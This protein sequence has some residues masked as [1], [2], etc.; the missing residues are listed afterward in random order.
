MKSIFLIVFIYLTSPCL[1]QTSNDTIKVIARQIDN[2][3][4][5]NKQ[6][7]KYEVLKVL[8]GTLTN[9]TIN[10]HFQQSIE[11][12]SLSQTVLLALSIR[13]LLVDNHDKNLF[14]IYTAEA[15]ESVKIVLFEFVDWTYCESENASSKSTIINRDKVDDKLFLIAPCTKTGSMISLIAR[16]MD[17]AIQEISVRGLECPPAIELTNLSDGRYTVYLSSCDFCIYKDFNLSSKP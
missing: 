15:I 13:P 6:L 17:Q 11:D 16:G 1:G 8:Q 10:V 7:K 3:N 14:P 4:A 2:R 12:Q 9:D 5:D